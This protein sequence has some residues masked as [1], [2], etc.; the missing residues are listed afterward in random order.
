MSEPADASAPATWIERQWYQPTPAGALLA[1]LGWLFGAG[2]A[3]RRAL[4]RSGA[5]RPVGLPVPVIVIGNITVGGSGKTPLTIHLAR[6]MRQA[7]RHPGIVSRGYGAQASHPRAVDASG[8]ARDFG[9][10]PLLI[11]RRTGCPVWVGHDRAAAAQALLAA[12]PQCDLL[13]ADDGLQHYRL[14]RDLEIAVVDGERPFGN[15]RLLPAGPL[16]E[17]VARLEDVDAIV[18]NGEGPAPVGRAP[19]FRMRLVPGPLYNL[20][21]PARAATPEELAGPGIHA[22]AGIGH[23]AR[24]FATLNS[25]GIAA[26]PHAFPDH[27]AYAPAD[28]DLPG[29]RAIVVT[30]KDALKCASFA[31]DRFWVLPVDAELDPDLMPL[32][33]N[34]AKRRHGPET[35]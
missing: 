26:V 9:D 34:A 10:E 23:P 20:R 17:P 11:A 14:A 16:R 6:A 18:I 28:L 22:A 8:S 33:L 19:I 29:A 30:E 1:P 15:G 25:L 2:A 35:A 7:G 32:L 27:H 13:L 24:F 21:D 5:F 31:D 12:H 4:F 3:L